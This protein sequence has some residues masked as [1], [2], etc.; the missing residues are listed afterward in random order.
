MS[1]QRQRG[2]MPPGWDAD[3]SD[4]Y[5]W[6]PLR[7]PPDVTRVSAS[8]R[9]SIE[10]EYRGWELTRVRLYTDGS[11]RVLLRRKKS[12]S[13]AWTSPISRRCDLSTPLRRAFFLV[14][15][16]THPHARL[17]CA[18][19]RHRARR[20]RR[21][22]L[23]DVAGAAGP[24]AG[25][26]GLRGAGSPAR[27]GLAAGF[28][29]DGLGPDDLGRAGFRLRRGRHGDRRRPQPGN[30]P[31]RL[32]RL[33]EDRALLNRMGF[34][35]HGAG[36]LALRLARHTP[37]VPIGV[38]IGKTKVTP[39]ERARRRLP[40]ERAAARRRWRPTWWSTSARRTPRGCATCR[41]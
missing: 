29:K 2:R 41:R 38:N 6:V 14:A 39:P 37:D 34:N 35:N 27:M 19:H 22:A 17:R 28:D 21:R 30:P 16:R 8:T 36:A 32:F 1:R 40:R 23:T 24:G 26:H 31:P 4:E 13:T 5:E 3:L 7:L 12:A 25:Q 15:R 20:R 18:A 33:P 9:L 11:R 10:A